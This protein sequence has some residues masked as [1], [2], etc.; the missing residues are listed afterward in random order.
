MQLWALLIQVGQ[1]NSSRTVAQQLLSVPVVGPEVFAM[2]VIPPGKVVR[3][4]KVGLLGWPSFLQ[5][6]AALPSEH[7]QPAG[8]LTVPHS[9]AF[10]QSSTQ[11]RASKCAGECYIMVRLLKLHCNL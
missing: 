7:G 9:Y 3:P 8:L 10:A 4:S 11:R 1:A 5:P 6:V 2:G